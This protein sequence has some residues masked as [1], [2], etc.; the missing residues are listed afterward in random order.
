MQLRNHADA[1]TSE[2]FTTLKRLCDIYIY[3]YLQY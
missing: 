2:A 3:I 1:Q